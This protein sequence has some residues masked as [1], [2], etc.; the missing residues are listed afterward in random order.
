MVDKMPSVELTKDGYKI[1][2][3]WGA[4][5]IINHY[6][7]KDTNERRVHILFDNKKEGVREWLEENDEGIDIPQELFEVFCLNYQ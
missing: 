7:H 5:L 4:S 6:R 2:D 3:Q 1:T